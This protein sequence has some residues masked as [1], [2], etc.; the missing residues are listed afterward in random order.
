M[1]L[2]YEKA[3]D[4][5]R[6]L[7]AALSV[8]EAD[9]ARPLRIGT[10]DEA[11]RLMAD[12]PLTF[13]GIVEVSTAFGPFRPGD[14]LHVRASDTW[15][16]HRWVLVEREGRAPQIAQCAERTGTR[17]LVD[18]QGDAVLYEPSRHRVLGRVYGRFEQI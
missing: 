6:V 17:V 15:E 18:T 3:C 8:A 9:E 16:L 2:S 5:S 11:G 7:G 10:I 4:V 13:P 14:Q 12:N 1:G